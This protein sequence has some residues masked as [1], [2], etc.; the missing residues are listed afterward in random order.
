MTALR[1]ASPAEIKR[2]KGLAAAGKSMFNV[3]NS[4]GSASR[5]CESDGDDD[6]AGAG[7][8]LW[9]RQ[10]R[11][12]IKKGSMQASRPESRSNIADLG[13][14]VLRAPQELPPLKQKPPLVNPIRPEASPVKTDTNADAQRVKSDATAQAS[15]CWEDLISFLE[16]HKLPGA[17]ALAFSAYGVEDLSSLLMLDDAG[18]SSLFEKCNI[19]AMD[20]ILLLEALRSTRAFQ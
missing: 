1:P 9:R 15:A 4:A 3:K 14:G 17:Y 2:P 18:L 11:D 20:E 7:E 19:D 13:A 12:K 16:L 10:Q 6:D 8:T 5:G